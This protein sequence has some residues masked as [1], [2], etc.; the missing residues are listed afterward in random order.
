LTG[1]ILDVS[2]SFFA[3]RLPFFLEK[4]I[5]LEESVVASLGLAA[6]G[7]DEGGVASVETFWAGAVVFRF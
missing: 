7:G 2:R 5:A 3:E 4:K 6:F 1:D